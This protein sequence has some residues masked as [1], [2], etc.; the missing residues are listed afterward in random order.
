MNLLGFCFGLFQ[1]AVCVAACIFFA[2]GSPSYRIYFSI[3]GS[4]SRNQAAA[5]PILSPSI[6]MGQALLAVAFVAQLI[7]LL[8][9]QPRGSLEMI[10][11]FTLFFAVSGTLIV[12][13]IQ[14]RKLYRHFQNKN[15][16]SSQMTI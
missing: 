7:D 12:L 11:I 3:S 15:G 10:E 8:L 16:A 9:R 13:G 4:S 14:Y 1:V 5:K 2:N 6:I